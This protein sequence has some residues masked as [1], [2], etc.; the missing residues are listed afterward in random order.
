MTEYDDD[1]NPR[2]D[3]QRD[4]LTELGEVK[5]QGVITADTAYQFLIPF[6]DLWDEKYA[7]MLAITEN[8]NPVQEEG[9]VTSA[10]PWT[11]VMPVERISKMLVEQLDGEPSEA[12]MIGR[13]STYDIR[14][15]QNMATLYDLLEM[16]EYADE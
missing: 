8:V 14:H 7:L 10:P 11:P 9:I 12:S 5:G 1:G 13:G 16:E 2:F 3:S 6:V 4:A 15:D